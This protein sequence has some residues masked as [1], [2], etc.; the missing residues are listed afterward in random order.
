MSWI[1]RIVGPEGWLARV[2]W[3]VWAPVG[4]ALLTIVNQGSLW[5]AGIDDIGTFRRISVTDPFYVIAPLLGYRLLSAAAVSAFDR[6]RPA[7]AADDEQARRRLSTSPTASATIAMAVGGAIGVSAYF[8]DATY[9]AILDAA[10]LTTAVWLI[11]GFLGFGLHIVLATLIVRQLRLVAA[12]HRQATEIDLFR[13]APVHAFASLTA[14]SGT[15]VLVL[16]LYSAFTD[17][18]TFTNPVWR[19]VFVVA[20]SLSAAAFFLPLSGLA[21]R[22]RSEKQDL[23]DTVAARMSALRRDLYG[24]ADRGSLTE[25]ADLRTAMSALGEDQERIRKVSPWP[26]ETATL[27]GFATTLLIPIA[28]WLITNLLGETLGL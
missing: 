26:W 17:P 25:V 1:D 21:R 18:S 24:A 9:T 11:A 20:I 16:A 5:A 4:W 10:S 15:V 3:W 23:L 13:P 12:L 6:F 22:L 28:T 2:P 19:V 7:L 8:S 27:R 14:R